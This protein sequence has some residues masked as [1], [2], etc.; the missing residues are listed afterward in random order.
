MFYDLEIAS[1]DNLT[2]LAASIKL[3]Q[4]VLLTRPA[5]KVRF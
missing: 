2:M 3:D 5:S 4:I 1:R